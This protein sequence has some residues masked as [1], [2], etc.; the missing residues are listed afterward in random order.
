MH[1]KMPISELVE[2]EWGKITE[3]IEIDGHGIQTLLDAQR[4]VLC[5]AQ[6]VPNDIIESVD[7]TE[8]YCIYEYLGEFRQMNLA[9]KKRVELGRTMRLTIH[10]R[11][12]KQCEIMDAE[13][14]K[15][16]QATRRVV[17]YS[18]SHGAPDQT[19]DLRGIVREVTILY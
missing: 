4:P 3:R 18:E 5:W 8:V 7:G 14:I 10:H 17:D 1:K 15:A 12:I 19:R 9:T 13:L 2:R 6:F 11:D 16:L